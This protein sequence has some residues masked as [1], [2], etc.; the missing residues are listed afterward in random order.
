MQKHEGI[1]W[2]NPNRHCPECND[3][4]YYY[5]TDA[6]TGLSYKEWCQYC[7]QYNAS[8]LPVLEP[9]PML[10]GVSHKV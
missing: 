2:R 1:C 5:E 4:G 9:L 7:K 8:K 3:K 10:Q 6:A